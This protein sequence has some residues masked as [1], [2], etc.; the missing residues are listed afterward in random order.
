[1]FNPDFCEKQC[2]IC[3]RARK[4]NPIAKVVQTI[5]MFLTFGRCPWG[6]ARQQKHGVRPNEPLPLRKDETDETH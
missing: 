5:E 4:G 3:T 2:P 1:M 6:R